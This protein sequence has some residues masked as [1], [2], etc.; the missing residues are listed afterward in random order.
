MDVDEHPPTATVVIIGY[1]N[2]EFVKQQPIRAGYDKNGGL[3][4]HT[5][6]EIYSKDL[7]P[8]SDLLS[9]HLS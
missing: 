4:S 3:G 2:R 9:I 1:V 8:I 5:N 7:L 6:Y